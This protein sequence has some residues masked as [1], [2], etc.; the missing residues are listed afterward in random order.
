MSKVYKRFQEEIRITKHL[1]KRHFVYLVPIWRFQHFR[2]HLQ[3]PKPQLLAICSSN[4]S[5]DL[6]FSKSLGPLTLIIGKL[7]L[8]R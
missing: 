7:I 2:H 4:H 5:L 3:N 6:Y 1:Q 8:N